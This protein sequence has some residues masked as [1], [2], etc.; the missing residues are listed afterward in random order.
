MTNLVTAPLSVAHRLAAESAWRRGVRPWAACCDE[1]RAILGNRRMD[2]SDPE[3]PAFLRS[4]MSRVELAVT[5]RD[6]VVFG[7]TVEVKGENLEDL[8]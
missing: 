1:A 4:D 2:P 7:S 6:A 8:P 3:S 5:L